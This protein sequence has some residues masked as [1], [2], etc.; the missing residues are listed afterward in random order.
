MKRR[1][2]ENLLRV[3]AEPGKNGFQGPEVTLDEESVSESAGFVLPEES[4]ELR[5]DCVGPGVCLI[6]FSCQNT[7]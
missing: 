7:T 6:L 3:G 5:N 1:T 2:G 4:E